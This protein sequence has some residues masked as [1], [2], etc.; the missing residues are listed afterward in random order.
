[1]A[2]SAA[3]AGRPPGALRRALLRPW[4]LLA[5]ALLLPGRL[6]AQEAAAAPGEVEVQAAYLVN[7][8]RYTQWPES[9]FQGPR[10][11]YVVTVVGSERAAASV[12]A[13]A[14]AAG[15]VGSRPIEVRWLRDARGSRAAPFDS[16]QDQQASAQLRGSHLVFFHSSGGR[17]HPQVLS[18]LAKQPVLTVSDD[19]AFTDGGGML[20][21]V[22]VGRRIVFQ[23]N[24]G[25]IRNAGLLV[26]AKVLK[27][28]RFASRSLQ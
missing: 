27:L 8:L 17:V 25:A 21:L 14:A 10:S 6:P 1:L 3:N 13:V 22:H 18:D 20:A 16:A 5:A 23:A 11:P 12:R 19:E 2:S 7:F 28:A 4:L 9:S 24:P 15:S 26:S